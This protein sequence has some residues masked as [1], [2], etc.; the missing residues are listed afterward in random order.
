MQNSD[1]SQRDDAYRSTAPRPPSQ[2][3]GPHHDHRGAP[4]LLLVR[5]HAWTTER[6]NKGNAAVVQHIRMPACIERVRTEGSPLAHSLRLHPDLLL[7]VVRRLDEA[8]RGGPASD[9]CG[10]VGHE[11]TLGERWGRMLS[12]SPTHR[13]VVCSSIHAPDHR[14]GTL[15]VIHLDGERP[16]D[17]Q[18]HD[19]RAGQRSDADGP[20]NTQRITS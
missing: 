15:A 5:C 11:P 13:S 9:Q 3:L 6:V 14:N 16:R 20:V 18:Q 17:G 8:L 10:V 1:L 12:S 2:S 19:G 4:E 7:L